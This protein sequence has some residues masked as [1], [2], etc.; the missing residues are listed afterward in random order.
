[1]PNYLEILRLDILK[2]D[3]P[4]EMSL[5]DYD[6]V[7]FL[8]SHIWPRGIDAQCVGVYRLFG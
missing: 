7:S 3:A 5:K 6:L 8:A 4:I 1:M 2:D